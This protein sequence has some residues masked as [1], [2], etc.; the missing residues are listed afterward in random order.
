MGLSFTHLLYSQT[1]WNWL[2]DLIYSLQQHAWHNEGTNLKSVILTAEK[3]AVW[4][5]V[6]RFTKKEVEGS[7]ICIF[8]HVWLHHWQYIILSLHHHLYIWVYYSVEFSILLSVN[9]IQQNS[10]F[11]VYFISSLCRLLDNKL[12]I[13]NEH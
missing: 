13:L 3:W 1:L 4:R 11:F 5:F 8:L 7:S 12:N 2:W 9:F 10:S 6:Q